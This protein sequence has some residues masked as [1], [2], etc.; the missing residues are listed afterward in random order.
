M[1]ASSPS[2]AVNAG[3]TSLASPIAGLSGGDSSLLKSMPWG[4]LQLAPDG[5]VV[6]LNPQAEALWGLP[7]TAVLGRTPAQVRPAVLPPELLHVLS[8]P[9]D[10][11]G[12]ATYW[13]PRTEQWVMMRTAPAAEGCVWVYW[14]NVTAAQ[15]TADAARHPQAGTNRLLRAVEE[16]AQAGSYEVELETMAFRFSDGLF[17]LFGEAPQSFVPSIEFID[18]RSH[19]D[20]VLKVQ[21][22]LNE[23]IAQKKPYHYLRRIYRNDGQMRT[24]EAHGNVLCNPQGQ[25]VALLG[26]VQDITERHLAQAHGLQ[27]K[28]EVAQRATDQYRALFNSM[29]QGYFLTE[30]LFDD[31]GRTLDILYLDANPAATRMVGQDM[32]GRRLKGMDPAYEA[33]WYDIFGR[34]AWTGVGERLVQYAEPDQRWYDFYVFR[35]GDKPS[36]RVAVIFQDVTERKRREAH[37][38]F[39]AKL[40]EEWSQLTTADEIMQA[41]GTRLGAYLGVATCRLSDIDE[42][43]DDGLVVRHG[44]TRSGVPV[45]L[46]RFRSRDY[47][48]EAFM[49]ASRDGQATIIRDTQATAHVDA[50][51]YAR[52]SIGALLGFPFHRN[53]QWK[54]FLTVTDTQPRDW[55]PEEV[56]L[57]REVTTRL[58]PRLE[59]ARAEEALRISEDRFRAV[60]NLVP[61]LLW[62]SDPQGLTQWL[63]QRWLDYTGQTLE[64]AAGWGWLDA[65]HPDDRA[66]SLSTFQ[67]SINEGVALRMEYRIRSV[68][69]EYRWF[70]G[71]ARPLVGAAGGI[72]QWFGA[73]TDIHEQKLAERAQAA[74]KEG[75]EQE[76]AERTQALQ[77]SH[78]LLQSIYNTSLVGMAVLEAVRDEAG[79]IQDFRIASVN[80]E[81]ERQTSRT[82]LAGKHYAQEYPGIV[83]SGLLDLMREV[84]ETGVPQH[85]EYFYPYDGFTTW[86]SCTF[87]KLGDGLVNTSLDI[88]SRKQAEQERLKHLVLLEQSEDVAQLGSWE[89]DLT[90]GAFSWSAGMFR[91]FGL[92][93]GATPAVD[94]YLQAAIAEDRPIAEKLVHA[95]QAG[96]PP[97]DTTLRIRVNNEVRTLKIEAKLTQDER[98]TTPKILGVDLDIS[99]VVRLEAENLRM[100]LQQ[101]KSLFDAVLE[102]QETERRRFAE[103]LHNGVGQ[104]LYATKLH[105]ERLRNTGVPDAWV[106]TDALLSDAIRQTRTLSHELVPTVL[107][108]FG[109][110]AALLAICRTLSTP[111][112]RLHS[113]VSLEEQPLPQ[114][115]QVAV[116]RMAQELVHN[117]VKHSKAS[118][119]CLTLETVP[120]FVLLRA[121]DNGIG[122]A[123]EQPSHSGIGLRTIRDRVALLGG[124]ADIGSSPEFGTYV[125]LRFPVFTPTE[126]NL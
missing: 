80:K 73:A 123:P 26:L 9:R 79:S 42:L 103:S 20:D 34:V 99:D 18:A 125:R 114:P 1:L 43:R 62:R 55:Q 28:E 19:P 86:F 98:G 17:R 87:G 102:A 30:V 104:T 101:Q 56:E 82:D 121:E 124:T 118:E 16:V 74:S 11:T 61:D 29:D 48:S 110:Q 64:E 5:V 81:L 91:L 105:L 122:F 35:I 57:V 119:A 72:E 94:M 65:V 106:Q 37:A 6:V 71:Q 126:P 85:Y 25:P 46:G 15:Q 36:Y 31:Q 116:Y 51:A 4:V 115:L 50:A 107:N 44:W 109:L 96:Q 69:G 83:T 52:L 66:V 8:R 10:L 76:V 113:S 70:L 27:A 21:H 88:T 54:Y 41:T 12:A 67:R 23:A 58:F 59:R 38:E 120:G 13:L 95:L 97:S 63:N 117:I 47:L 89:Y 92:S 108:E 33:Y 84:T 100:R 49:Q 22:V 75:L 14:D 45:A 60:A 24:L 7:A 78:A 3:A 2:P 112:L 32:T 53:G 68:A 39:Q 93:P 90:T 40:L 77:G 111:A